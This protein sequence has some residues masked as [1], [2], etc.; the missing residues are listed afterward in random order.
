MKP[1][2]HWG[3]AAFRVTVFIIDIKQGN[4]PSFIATVTEVE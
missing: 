3:T 4:N 2:T 1:L